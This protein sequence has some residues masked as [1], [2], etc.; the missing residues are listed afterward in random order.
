MSYSDVTD[1]LVGDIRI[2]S[3]LD[4][5]KY[6]QDAS[7]EVDSIIGFRYATPVDMTDPGTVSR[8]ARLLLKRVANFLATGRLIIAAAASGEDKQLH[9][10]GKSLVD[11]ALYC[12]KEIAAGEILLPGAAPATDVS[13]I[14]SGPLIYN[15]DKTSNVDD[16]YDK[17]LAP[18]DPQ[19]LVRV[20]PGAFL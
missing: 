18:E 12:L 11:Q 5:Q 3:A 10:Y 7:D 2:N 16:F 8:P 17:I 15:K 9:A 1:L 14:I 13:P 4:P 20:W 19:T 6:V